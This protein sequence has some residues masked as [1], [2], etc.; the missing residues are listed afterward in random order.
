MIYLIVLAVI[1]ILAILVKI[2]EKCYI[3]H[4]IETLNESEGGDWYYD[5]EKR[6][7]RD[8]MTDRFVNSA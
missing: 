1:L 2:F 4:M 8:S 6:S 5:K 3:N 7:Y